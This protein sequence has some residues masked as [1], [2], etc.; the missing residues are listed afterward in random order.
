MTLPMDTPGPSGQRSP[1]QPPLPISEPTSSERL[2][3]DKRDIKRGSTLSILGFLARLCARIPFLLIAGRLYG[4]ATYGEYVLLT[5]IVETTA[6]LSTF[7]LKRTIFR[8]IGDNHKDS[9]TVIRH[10]LILA[11]ALSVALV[12]LIQLT[13]MPVLT[14]FSTPDSV[15][16]LILLSWAIPFISL[17][18]IFLSSTLSKRLM[19]YEITV[20]SFVE[21]I[22]LTVVSLG[23]YF[24]GLTGV[25][26]IAAFVTAFAT[27]AAFSAYHCHET[28]GWRHILCGPVNMATLADMAH[29]SASTC[30]HDL[31]RVLVTRLDTFAV[32]Y[33]FSTTAVGLYGMAQQFLTIVEKVAASF[34][35]MLMPV[36]SSAVALGDRDRLLAQLKSAARR[37]VLLQLPVVLVFYFL[38]ETLLGLI[39]AEFSAAWQVLM[40]LSLGCWVNSVIQLVEIPLTYMRPSIN[41][42]GCLCAIAGYLAC[43]SLMQ[44]TFGLNGIAI[45]SVAAG[46]LSNLVLMTVFMRTQI[47]APQSGQEQ[48]S[49]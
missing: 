15:S 11:L 34:Y 26:L 39:G 24:S 3:Q 9:P 5:A 45:T 28:F 37:L 21:P 7:G 30:L 46:F 42:F 27:A 49:A 41:V 19:R 10:A 23:L 32:G 2:D 47:R 44:R 36:V 22:T 6:L 48:T 25:G 33:F 40:I 31:V 29:H 35:P 13:A 8:F 16:N 4:S 12:A 43:V 18:D 38:G 14:F 20:R 1:S 17:T